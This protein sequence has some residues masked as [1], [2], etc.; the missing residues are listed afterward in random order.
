MK[1]ILFWMFVVGLSEVNWAA[2]HEIHSR[3]LKFSHRL[4]TRAGKHLL[5][6]RRIGELACEILPGE[7]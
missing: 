2:L 7:V 4:H 1:P 6:V 3:G 5:F